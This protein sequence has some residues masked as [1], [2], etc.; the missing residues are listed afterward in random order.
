MNK[1]TLL[2]Q[3]KCRNKGC[4]LLAVWQ[5]PNGPEYATP[6]KPGFEEA[7]RRIGRNTEGL[8]SGGRL[9]DMPWTVPLICDHT[10]QEVFGDVVRAD[11]AGRTPGKPKHV[12]WWGGPE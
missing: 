8:A 1:S 2:V 7:G 3:Y 4:P 9:Q 12:L 11:A 6:R 10:Y 5:T